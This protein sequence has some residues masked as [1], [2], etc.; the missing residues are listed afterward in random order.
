MTEPHAGGTL[1]PNTQST[2]P[3]KLAKWIGTPFGWIEAFGQFVIVRPTRWLFSRFDTLSYK[4]EGTRLR[5][6]LAWS[7]YPVFMALTLVIGFAFTANGVTS[8]SYLGNIIMFLIYGLVFAPLER[9]MPY[10]RKWLDG[11]NDVSVDI[12]IYLAAK[13][14][15]FLTGT[16]LQLVMIIYLVEV[17]K[18]Y[19]HGIWPTYLPAIVQVFLLLT[20][21]DFFRYW[22][23]RWMHEN[24]FMWR[25]HAAHHSSLRLYWFNGQRHHPLEVVVSA[26]L[27]SV[28]LALVQAPV[29]IAFVAFM[30]GRTI[31]RFQHTNIDVELGIFDYIFSS[32]KNHRYHHSKL[33]EE[34]N[35]NYGGD[36]ILWDHLFGTFYMPKGQKPSDD[37]GIGSSPNYPQTWFGIL[38]APFRPDQSSFDE[39]AESSENT[40]T[41]DASVPAE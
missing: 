23:H 24:A 31:G 18:P 13:F 1:S 32:P 17:M 40:K 16:L 12:M 29:E 25:W 11:D 9:L 3:Q 27:W 39:Q 28:P 19:G 30:L 33:L 7:I 41:K 4:L 21:R 34:G 2:V 5:K 20:I 22:Y 6:V 38:L 37:I 35:S 36:I 10:S 8:F 14:W 15:G 26:L